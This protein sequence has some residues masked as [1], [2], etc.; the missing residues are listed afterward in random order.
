MGA[1]DSDDRPFPML[2]EV[3]F[4]AR[5]EEAVR[6][7]RAASVSALIRTALGNF[8][9]STVVPD[10]PPQVAISV[11][12]GAEQREMLRAAAQTQ[13]TSIGHLVRAAV[14]AHLGVTDEVPPPPPPP[15]KPSGVVRSRSKPRP[16]PAP[17]KPA[18]P[19]AVRPAA[20]PPARP[21]RPAPGARPKRT[22]AKPR[23]RPGRKRRRAR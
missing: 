6:A 10:R 23:A 18:P 15:A 3:A 7:G 8:D 21:A 5:L 11:R 1:A 2:L 22:V 9:P 4:R 13:G 12:L 16:K 17:P 20:P 19:R 14:E